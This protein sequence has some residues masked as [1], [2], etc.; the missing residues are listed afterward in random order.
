MIFAPDSETAPQPV[1]TG[2]KST[3]KGPSLNFRLT[4]RISC[5]TISEYMPIREFAG[6][7]DTVFTSLRRIAAAQ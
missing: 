5:H 4:E 6:H 3:R 2:T 7:K 1:R